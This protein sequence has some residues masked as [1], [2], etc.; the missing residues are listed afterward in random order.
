LNLPFPLFFCLRFYKLLVDLWFLVNG[1]RL[2][3]I[4]VG[5]IVLFFTAVCL[6]GCTE[7]M[8]SA[9]NKD[10]Q[11]LS[12]NIKGDSSFKAVYGEIKNI[13]NREIDEVTVKVNFYNVSNVLLYTKT[14]T[15]IHLAKGATGNFSVNYWYYESGFDEYDHYVVFVST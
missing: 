8:E 2:K 1:M 7:H 14:T 9:V 15:I 4:L 5:L 13:A 3:L 12:Q 11:I 6:S 10:V